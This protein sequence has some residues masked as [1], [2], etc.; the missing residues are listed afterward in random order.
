MKILLATYWPLPHIGGVWTYLEILRDGLE[1][2]GYEVDIFAQHPDLTKYYLIKDGQE[3]EKAPLLAAA[4]AQT[5]GQYK[6]RDIVLSPWM[7]WRESEKRAFELACRQLRLDRYD[8]IHSQD[9]ISTFALARA[10]PSGV[11]LVATI[12]GCLATE[13]VANKEIRVRSRLERHHLAL[14]EYYGAMTPDCLIL[15]SRWLSR[16]LSTFQVAHPNTYIVP[17]GLSQHDF[18]PLPKEDAQERSPEREGHRFIIA[19]PARLVAIKGQTH[20]LQAMKRLIERRKDAVCWLIGDGV[21]RGE[22]ER[23]IRQMRL[24]DHVKLLGKRTDVP[25]LLSCADVVALPSLQ[26]NL[27][28]SVIEAQSLGK[29]VV[30]SSVGGIVEM[31]EEGVTGYLVEPG[32]A[33]ALYEKLL[34]LAD[35]CALRERLSRTAREHSKQRWNDAVMIDRTVRAY[36]DAAGG[37]RAPKAAEPFID[38]MECGYRDM[39]LETKEALVV[40]T[41]TLQGTIKDASSGYAVSDARVHL[42]DASGVVLRSMH[43]GA[44]GEFALPGVQPGAYELGCFSEAYGFKTRAVRISSAGRANIEILL[45]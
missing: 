36:M 15:P 16:C 20:L 38:K 34:L 12:H 30:A 39:L 25:N 24:G 1:R 4:E 43:C 6:D 40:P 29:P 42:L 17:Y 32:N 26:D 19:C 2:R 41:M 31:I 28:F 21:M 22:L 13:W 23:Q 35:D 8:V 5:A 10:K 44:N 33:E 3:V 7:L 11:P 14:E 9:I 18:H 45:Q 37:K 27:P